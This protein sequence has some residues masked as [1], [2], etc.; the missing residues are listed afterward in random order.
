MGDLDIAIKDLQEKLNWYNMAN[1]NSFKAFTE[2]EKSLK[3]AI[4]ILRNANGDIQ[5]ILD[6][7]DSFERCQICDVL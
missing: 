1:M 7:D 5:D 3:K 2:H 6:C 4:N